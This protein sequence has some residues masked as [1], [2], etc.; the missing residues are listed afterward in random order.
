MPTNFWM[1]MLNEVHLQAK[2][3]TSGESSRRYVEAALVE[4]EQFQL[5]CGCARWVKLS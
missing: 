1:R 4:L 2:Q 3:K 5:Y